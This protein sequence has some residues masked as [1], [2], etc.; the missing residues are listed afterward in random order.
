MPDQGRGR[1]DTAIDRAV[2]GMMQIDPRP[3]LRHR[4]AGRLEAPGRRRLWLGPAL[5]SAALLA[6][7]LVSIV[8][9][10]APQTDP[11]RAPQ[12]AAAPPSAPLP[13]PEVAREL[14]S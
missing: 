8:W 14:P 12:V 7:V 6:V 5:A 2:R 9:L 1:L 13:R 10:R 3:G 4:V 11:A